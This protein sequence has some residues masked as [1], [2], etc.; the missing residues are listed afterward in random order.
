MYLLRLWII[1]ESLD[2]IKTPYQIGHLDVEQSVGAFMIVD[3]GE[4]SRV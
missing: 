1:S 2:Q 3:V 4:G